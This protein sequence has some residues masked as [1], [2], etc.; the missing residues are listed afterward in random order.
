MAGKSPFDADRQHLH[1]RLLTW[2]TRTASRV[3][4][5]YLW[6]ALFSGRW[7]A[8]PCCG[9]SLI[10]FALATVV[11]MAALLLA[12]MP[13]LR[14]WRSTG[15]AGSKTS[16]ADSRPGP[17]RTNDATGPPGCHAGRSRAC[18][19]AAAAGSVGAEGSP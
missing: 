10:W 19:R 2:A 12:T 6:A 16:P 4:L 14:P 7:S 1:H 9:S 17:F 18:P 8:C 11:A 13:R 5:M 3:L 15:G